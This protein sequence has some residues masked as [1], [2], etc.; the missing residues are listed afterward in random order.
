LG[1]LL[2]HQT[3][4]IVSSDK[5]GTRN[6]VNQAFCDFFGHD[7]DYFIGT[8]Y[9]TLNPENV[10]QFYL[11]VFDSISFDN[12]KITIT[13]I[14]EN[15]LGQ[16]RWIK[17]DEIGFF[18]A[19]K[20]VI[21]IL[22]IGHDITEM[23]ENE[24]QNANYIAQFEELAFKN[25]HHFR[26]PLSNI[27]G[28]INL[29]DNESTEEEISELLSI[30]K[31]EI[32]D[33]DSSSQELSNFINLH[34]KSIKHDK[35]VFNIDFINAKL[36][37]LKWKYKI[38]HFLD[39]QGSLSESQAVSPLES[40]FGKWYYNEGKQK[41]GHLESVRKLEIQ[42]EK[43]HQLVREILILQKE[44]KKDLAEEKYKQLVRISDKIIILLDES[45]QFINNKNAAYLD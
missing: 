33:L 30:I 4:L 11:R 13:I 39:G 1:L 7:K 18:N 28:V 45:E 44:N 29:I 6:Y 42:H 12:P 19:D 10:D 9:R 26:K 5:F 32:I 21:E 16:K 43:M 8:N 14:R 2:E 36:M 27:L 40:D 25:S 24:F 15:A 37:H 22:S 31:T 38:K 3:D 20:E 34:S 17:W 35:E 41:Y 23:K